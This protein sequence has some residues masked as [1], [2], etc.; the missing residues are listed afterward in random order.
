MNNLLSDSEVKSLS[1]AFLNLDERYITIANYGIVEQQILKPLMND[2]FSEFMDNSSAYTAI[3]D[4]VKKAV[5]LLVGI[6][7]ASDNGGS[8]T[9]NLG[10]M[11]A[12]TRNAKTAGNDR[13]KGKYEGIYIDAISIL[14][15]VG[16]TMIDNATDY[17]NFDKKK[18]FLSIDLY[19]NLGLV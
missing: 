14:Q 5:A 3:V 12:F 1:V 17:P 8:K 19:E 10:E 18:A 13:R 9:Q 16:E 2:F 7:A 15:W 4:D 11:E 6:R